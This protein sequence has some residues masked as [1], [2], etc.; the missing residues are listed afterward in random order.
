M[1]DPILAELDAIQAAVDR[2]RQAVQP[3]EPV[4]RPV[5]TSDELHAGLLEGGTLLLQA[6]TRFEG[7]FVVSQSG[8]TLVGNGAWL[9]GVQGPALYVPPGVHDFRGLDFS[10]T[11]DVGEVITLGANNATQTQ[12]EQIPQRITLERVRIPE[13]HH[14]YAHRGIYN[15]AADTQLLDCEVLNVWSPVGIET[16]CVTSLNTIGALLVRGGSYT[17]ASI[18]L[19]AGGEAT[20]LPAGTHITNVT[21]E[22]TPERYLQ[23]TKPPELFTNDTNE[24]LKNLA[25]VKDGHDVTFRYVE[26]AV[27]SGPIQR[28]FGSMLT[29]KSGGSVR[30][31]TYD[32]VW[33]HDVGSAINISGRQPNVPEGPRTTGIRILHSRFDIQHQ[34]AEGEQGWFLL[35]AG[36]VGTVDVEDTVILLTGTSLVVVDD[37]Q[38]IERLAFRRCRIPRWPR[39]GVKTPLGNHAAR[40]QEIFDVLEFTDCV[41]GGAPASFKALFPQNTYT[42]AA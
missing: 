3:E 1:S 13:H 14:R 35:L 29:P 5:T 18:N 12:L 2:I 6:G 7:R 4:G 11:S 20:R 8:T 27:S 41:I 21:Y 32:H 26:M 23:I 9:H 40:W 42:E 37:R 17:G 25:E 24:N 30:N 34:A 31:I 10:A 19:M 39:Y 33:M 28:G 38:R 22:G 36:G 16:H 15:C